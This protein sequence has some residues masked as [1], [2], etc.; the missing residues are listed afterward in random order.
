M[1]KRRFLAKTSTDQNLDFIALLEIGRDNFTSQF[2]GTL[3]GG[4]DFDWHCLPPRGRSGGILQR[5]KCEA[6]EEINVVRGDFAVMFRVRYKLDGF[7]WSLVAVYRAAQ[8]ELKPD[9]LADLVRICADERVP[10]LVGGDFNIIK[11]RDE[12]ATTLM[13]VGP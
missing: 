8:P 13:D 6:L 4:I 3:A 10:V 9:F 11:R 5:V 2:L 12:K 7:R 1:A